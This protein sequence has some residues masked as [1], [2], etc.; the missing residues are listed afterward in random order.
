[1]LVITEAM[2]RGLDGGGPIDCIPKFTAPLVLVEAV[3]E[4]LSRSRAA[5]AST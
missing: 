5:L 4:L 1:M 3:E 2:P